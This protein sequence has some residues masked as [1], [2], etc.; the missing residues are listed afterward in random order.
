[1]TPSN[2]DPPYYSADDGPTGFFVDEPCE[3]CGEVECEAEVCAA[4]DASPKTAGAS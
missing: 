2:L 4:W 1:M 3:I